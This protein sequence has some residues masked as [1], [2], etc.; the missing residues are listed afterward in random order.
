M[1]LA[2][3]RRFGAHLL[4]GLPR[5]DPDTWVMNRCQP[6][7]DGVAD[8]YDWIRSRAHHSELYPVGLRPVHTFPKDIFTEISADVMPNIR[9]FELDLAEVMHHMA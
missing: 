1:T 7:P 9:D 8:P 4:D 6:V 2:A 3:K 5:V